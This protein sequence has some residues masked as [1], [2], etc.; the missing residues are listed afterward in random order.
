MLEEVL[1]CLARRDYFSEELRQKLRHH[2]TDV[3]NRAIER[4][5]QMGYLNDKTAALRAIEQN[6]G[7]SAVSLTKLSDQLKGRHASSEALEIFA[8]LHE[9]P[10]QIAFNILTES[11]FNRNNFGS[12]KEKSRQIRRAA[13]LLSRRGFADDEIEMA[14]QH[15]FQI[16]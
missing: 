4:A 14:L 10:S 5:E 8:T 3:V 2:P 1:G 16:S 6:Q 15:F 13:Q 12:D 11:K 7:K 9:E